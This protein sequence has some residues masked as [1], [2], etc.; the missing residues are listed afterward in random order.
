MITENKSSEQINILHLRNTCLRKNGSLYLPGG[1]VFYLII[2][3]KKLR[4]HPRYYF[5]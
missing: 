2:Y 3:F 4:F 1:F 5:S